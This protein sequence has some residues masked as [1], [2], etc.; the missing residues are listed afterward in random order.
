MIA[1]AVLR[2][3]NVLPREADVPVMQLVYRVMMPC[4]ILDKI[5]GSSVLRSGP[6]VIWSIVLGYG[7]I[8]LGIGLGMVIA[9]ALGMARGSGMRTFALSAGCQNFGFTAVPVVQM[10]WGTGALAL[11]FVHNIGTE[12]AVWSVGIMVLGGDQPFSLRRLINGPIIGVVAG[13]ILVALNLDGYV[14]GAPRTAMSMMGA[15][16]FP[17]A[18]LIT[19]CSMMDLVGSERMCWKVMAGGCLVRLG[20]APAA[21]LCA[22]KYLPLSTELKQVMV[23]QAAMPAGLS[24]VLLVR[25]YGGRPGVAI[26]VIVATTVV[27][28]LTAPWIIAWGSTWLGLTPIQP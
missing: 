27:S 2:R 23:V 3:T 12:A 5:L 1:G 25:M 6:V 10:L 28:L 21:M 15:G 8:V 14:T 16:A 20:L 4:F 7:M 22:A 18:I 17:V 19:G 24:S 9:R 11:L 13:L 26:Q